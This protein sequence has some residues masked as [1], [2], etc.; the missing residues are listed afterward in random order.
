MK[1]NVL[2]VLMYL[3]D[4]YL[5]DETDPQH[6]RETL[7][8]ELEEAGFDR[9]EVSK[10]FRWLEGLGADPSKGLSLH[11]EQSLRV[12]SREE[13]LRLDAECRGFLI[14]LEQVGILNQQ[15]RELVIDR[16]MALDSDEIDIDQV[17]WIILMVLFNQPGQEQNFAR[18]EDLVFEERVGA[19]H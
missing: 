16:I 8:I 19:V 10:A 12:F 17:K 3:F 2:D 5:E 1:E 7:R 18:M 6:D 14:Y 4:N 9:H 13:M 15:E 11:A